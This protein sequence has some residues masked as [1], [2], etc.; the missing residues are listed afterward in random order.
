MRLQNES[1]KPPDI[2]V[3]RAIEEA[4]EAGLMA[5]K[6]KELVGAAASGAS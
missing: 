6:S 5:I 2:R 4:G 1:G 3:L